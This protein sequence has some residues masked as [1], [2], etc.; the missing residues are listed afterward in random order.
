MPDD[1]ALLIF[2]KKYFPIDWVLGCVEGDFND[3]EARSV[4]DHVVT[5]GL[6]C[7]F[8]K[9]YR[10]NFI[11]RKLL[12]DN[13]PWL[14]ST[15]TEK[16]GR[17]FENDLLTMSDND[18]Q[19]ADF[20]PSFTRDILVRNWM[21][22]KDTIMKPDRQKD[23]P[24]TS[25]VRAYKWS[26]KIGDRDEEHDFRRGDVDGSFMN[27]F[28]DATDVGK[29]R[30]GDF[31]AIVFKN[32]YLPVKMTTRYVKKYRPMLVKAINDAVKYEQAVLPKKRGIAITRIDTI[33]AS[34]NDIIEELSTTGAS[35]ETLKVDS[36]SIAEH[37]G[38]LLDLMLFNED[39]DQPVSKSMMKELVSKVLEKGSI[40]ELDVFLKK[41]AESDRKM[42]AI[43]N[44]LEKIVEETEKTINVKIKEGDAMDQEIKAIE[45]EGHRQWKQGMY[46]Q[47]HDKRE[48][49]SKMKKERDVLYDKKWKAESDLEDL[50]P[51]VSIPRLLRNTVIKH[52][53]SNMEIKDSPKR[54]H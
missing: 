33:R 44:H 15:T 36:P 23:N 38:E 9:E 49:G 30:I 18:V 37:G 32:E 19:D 27:R 34:I 12:S 3:T 17:A 5:R 42:F 25:I 20:S 24:V 31:S 10:K 6:A 50:V 14:A 35:N 22:D 48:L 39:K 4:F 2:K 40:G 46:E 28:M 21:V 8:I 29:D 16:M 51:L 43:K 52:P 1:E 41:A 11:T 7:P 53:L 13:S 47:L 45:D 54:R 26:K